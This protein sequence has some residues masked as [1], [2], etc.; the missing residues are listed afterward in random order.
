MVSTK[1]VIVPSTPAAGAQSSQMTP[2]S[3]V[4]QG[5]RKR[6]GGEHNRERRRNQHSERRAPSSY[7][8]RAAAASSVLSLVSQPPLGTARAS[9]APGF[10]ARH[11]GARTDPVFWPFAGGDEQDLASGAGER[12]GDADDARAGAVVLAH[13]A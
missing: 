8:S 11:D 7:A 10:A 2:K 3:W 9:S 1:R 12:D 4:V 6:Q 13:R 5:E